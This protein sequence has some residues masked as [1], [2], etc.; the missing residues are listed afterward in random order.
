M[1]ECVID[2]FWPMISFCSNF[3]S[4]TLSKGNNCSWVNVFIEAL[5]MIVKKLE[6]TL[7]YNTRGMV[8]QKILSYTLNII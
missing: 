7:V 1:R 6:T 3:I 2:Y 5:L 8:K 4:T